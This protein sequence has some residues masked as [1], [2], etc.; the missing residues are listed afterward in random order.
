MAEEQ[1]ASYGGQAVIE[2][3]MIRGKDRVATACRNHAG[4]IIVHHEAITT[5]TTKYPFLKWP[6]LRGTPAL[7]DSFSL[8]YRTLMWSADIAMEGEEEQA[9]PTPL[10]YFL[11]IATALAFGI[12][13]FVLLPTLM[14]KFIPGAHHF[15]ATGTIWQQLLPTP[16]RILPNIAEGIIRLLFLVAYILIIGNNK[17]IKRVFSYHGAEHKVVNSYEMGAPLTVEG[18]RPYSRIHP[19]CGTSFLFL[20]FVVGILHALIGWPGNVGIRMLSRIIMI[21]LIAGVSYELLRLAG[22]YRDSLLLKIMVWPGMAL[23]QLTTAEP[24][25]DQIEVALKSMK[26]VLEDEGVLAPEVVEA[27]TAD[28]ENDNALT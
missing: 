17:E 6:F 27:M 14:T 22:R 5:A 2:G 10:Q 19:R 7:I 25:D 1:R 20:F 15:E 18:A 13:V 9:K 3:V 24:T 4:E 11:T 21:P 23:Q 26:T 28:E 16:G 12:G 8:G